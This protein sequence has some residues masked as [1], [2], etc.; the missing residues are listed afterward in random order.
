MEQ[1]VNGLKC[2]TEKARI[3]RSTWQAES[4]VEAEEP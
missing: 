3:S 4:G 2:D 1:I